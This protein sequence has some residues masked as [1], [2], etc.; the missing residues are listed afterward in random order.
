MG[1]RR[2]HRHD[3]G[4]AQERAGQD[5]S[6]RV[7]WDIAIGVA[8][9]DPREPHRHGARRRPYK[10]LELL[11]AAKNGSQ[12]EGVRP[13]GQGPRRPHRR[14]PVPRHPSTPSTWCRSAP[15]ARPAPPTRQLA[16]KVT[17]VGIIGAG[18]M[19][20]QFALLFVRRLQVPGRDH[21]PRPGAR[22][23][24]PGLHP[25]R[26]R[27]AA[28]EGPDHRRRGQP[29]Q[30]ASSPAPRTRRDF[31]DCDWVIEA[32]FEE[33]AVK[34]DGLRRGRAVHLPRGHPRHQHLV[35]VGRA[36]RREAR[37]TR[38]GSSASTSSTRS[39]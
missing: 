16:Q 33:L 4:E 13:R 27:R 22:G 31:A 28:G 3:Q 11:K 9:E 38:S 35:T 5:S 19:A 29:P 39:P 12:E 8:R 14:R 24:G 36:D 23:Q 30:G 15:S 6:A 1:R 34:Q 7:K 37:R 21:R 18:L 10:A 32:V 2:A 20:S 26:D 17:K 25:R